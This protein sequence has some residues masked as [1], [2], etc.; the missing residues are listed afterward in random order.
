MHS[1]PSRP[2]YPHRDVLQVLH[3]LPVT[4]ERSQPAY[5]VQSLRNDFM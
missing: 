4:Q 1:T 5:K 2:G 3:P